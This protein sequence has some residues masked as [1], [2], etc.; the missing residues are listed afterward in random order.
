MSKKGVLVALPTGFGKSLI[1]LP[2]M[3]DYIRSCCTVG[4]DSVVIVV[5]PLSAFM[6]DQVQK[7]EGV[8]NVCV[9]QSVGEE[10][11]E[12]KVTIPEDI[13]KCCL[14]FGHPEVFDSWTTRMLPKCLKRKG[15]SHCCGRGSFG[16]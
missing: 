8:L 7:L 11:G 5:S 10:E 14:M 15:A 3:F 1:R 9:L 12:G 6:R 4:Q 13:K 2:S 16:S